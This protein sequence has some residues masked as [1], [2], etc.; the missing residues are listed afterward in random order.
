MPLSKWALAF[1][2][3]STSLKGVSSM[4]LHRDLG[5]TQKTAWHLAH[6]IRETW[7]TATE[8][9]AGPVEVDETYVGGKAT[10]RAIPSKEIVVVAK[11]RATGQVK[12]V[13]VPNTGKGTL[14][15]SVGR[16][17]APGATGLHGRAPLL[18]RAAV[19]ARGRQPPRRR[20]RTGA[21]IHAGHRVVL[22]H[23]QARLHGHIPPP[24][25]EA[26]EPLRRGV[27]GAA[28]RPTA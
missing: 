10:P 22:E 5:V 17:V 18:P 12:A 23:A 7:D 19:Q 25:R 2:L 9:F 3:L 16:R 24:E 20:V 21:G 11:D 14:Q 1:Y 28:Q 6:R 26:P 13:V 15:T 8:R 4:K 27:R